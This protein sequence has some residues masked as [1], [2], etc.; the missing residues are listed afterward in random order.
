MVKLHL[1]WWNKLK[2]EILES[3][4]N[5]EAVTDS[6]NAENIWGQQATKMM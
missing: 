2:Y 5:G 1:I 6:H 4:G 3:E